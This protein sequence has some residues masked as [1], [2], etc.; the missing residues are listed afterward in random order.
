MCDVRT[1]DDLDPLLYSADPP[2]LVAAKAATTEDKA[3][4]GFLYAIRLAR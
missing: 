1:I 4:I 2:E 3:Q